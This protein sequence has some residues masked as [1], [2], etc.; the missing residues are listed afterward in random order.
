MKIFFY[1][2]N[3]IVLAWLVQSSGE[4]KLSQQILNRLEP[5]LLNFSGIHLKIMLNFAPLYELSLVLAALCRWIIYILLMELLF[6]VYSAA[7]QLL[8]CCVLL[9][10]RFW[11]KHPAAI[12]C[13]LN[14]Y[15]NVF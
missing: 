5:I 15:L 10:N 14:N 8:Q 2:L 9:V 4:M 6:Y 3:G 12:G 13:H 7:H 11:C 1:L